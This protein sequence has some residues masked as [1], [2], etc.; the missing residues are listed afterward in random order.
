MTSRTG[1]VLLICFGSVVALFLGCAR[2][3]RPLLPQGSILILPPRD[4]IQDGK[5]HEAGA[6][7]GTKLLQNLTS[8]FESN[9]WRVILTDN[10]KFTDVSIATEH[11]A[12]AEGKR[13]NAHYVLQVVLGEFRDAAPMTF[14]A[15]FVTLQGAR[16]WNVESS[17][18]IWALDKPVVYSKNNLGSYYSLLDNISDFIVRSIAE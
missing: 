12:L 1:T 15:D 10:G 16:L 2:P 7:S 4:V 13:L 5:P 8:A 3:A 18:L 17:Q 9:G 11:N 6:D 14:R